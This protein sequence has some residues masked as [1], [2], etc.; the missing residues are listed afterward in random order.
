MQSAEVFLFFFPLETG[1]ICNRV[2]VN[3]LFF[4]NK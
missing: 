3:S 1:Q 4:M 2:I